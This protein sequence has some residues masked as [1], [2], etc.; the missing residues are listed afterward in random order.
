MTRDEFTNLPRLSEPTEI[1]LHNAVGLFTVLADLLD[2]GTG[3]IRPDPQPLF[4]RLGIMPKPDRGLNWLRN[5]PHVADYL[6][7]LA[8][9]TIPL[10]HD[11]LHELPSWRT[12]AHLRDLLIDCAAYFLPWT[13]RAWLS[14]AGVATRSTNT[15]TPRAPG[16]CG[17]SPPGTSCPSCTPRPVKEHSSPTPVTTP[18]DKSTPRS[19]S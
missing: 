13:V 6:R 16:C 11:A 19:A 17:S 2:D 8:R 4:S 10:T 14:S 12:A 15:P 5:N 1:D 3:Q 7:C 18:P 9:G